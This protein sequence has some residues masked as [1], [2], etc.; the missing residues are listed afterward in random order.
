MM[1]KQFILLSSILI[2]GTAIT[3]FIIPLNNEKPDKIEVNKNIKAQNAKEVAT[4]ITFAN[5]TLNIS[6]Q[7]MTNLLSG[8]FICYDDNWKPE[9]SYTE[10][11]IYGDLKIRYADVVDN[12]LEFDDSI[13]RCDW[14]IKLNKNIKNNLSVKIA[15]GESNINLE[16][17]NLKRFELNMLA[18]DVKVNLKNANI[19]YLLVNALVGEATIDL[20]GTWKND[21]NANITGGIGELNIILPKN[22]GVKI[23]INGLLGNVSFENMSKQDRIYTNSLYGKTA[24]TVYIQ[25]QG[26]LGNIN[27]K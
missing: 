7:E 4:E 23:Q 20:S 22:T 21:L 12:D 24:V 19:P 13:G 16:N 6:A 1:K 15:A 25:I 8:K 26:G 5:G 18:G 17:S 27:L 3:S 9:I 2:T 11:G 14:N 10:T